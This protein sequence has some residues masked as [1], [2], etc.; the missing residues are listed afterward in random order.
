[1]Q[2]KSWTIALVLFSATSLLAQ[3]PQ[4]EQYRGVLETL[5]SSMEG[6]SWNRS[7]GWMSSAP[8]SEWYGITVRDGR[9]VAI[10][11]PNNGLGGSG[12]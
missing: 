8:V 5:Y 2:F 9:L 1:M 12:T 7:D 6:D 3:T 10:A 11:L 4:E